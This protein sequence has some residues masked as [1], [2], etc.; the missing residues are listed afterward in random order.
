MRNQYG[1]QLIENIKAYL[2]STEG[3]VI[4]TDKEE[5][6]KEIILSCNDLFRANELSATEIT[7]TIQKQFSCSIA[8]AQMAMRA[9]QLVFATGVYN[10]EYMASIHLEDIRA[11]IRLAK[12]RGDWDAV[13]KLRAIETKA[14]ELLPVVADADPAPLVINLRIHA[15]NIKR[16]VLP[17]SDAMIAGMQLLKQLQSGKQENDD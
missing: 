7:H 8:K 1:D 14:I 5:E 13:I 2:S 12:A 11:D 15:G 17:V 10:K 9:T 6:L 3:D 16:P 4:L